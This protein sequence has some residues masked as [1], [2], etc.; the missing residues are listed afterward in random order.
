MNAISQWLDGFGGIGAVLNLLDGDFSK[1]KR[2]Q[3]WTPQS[4]LRE[5]YEYEDEISF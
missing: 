5:T 2:D 1:A 4:I 3:D